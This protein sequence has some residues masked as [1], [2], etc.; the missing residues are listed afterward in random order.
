M[1]TEVVIGFL[2]VS[3]AIGLAVL[4]GFL[5]YGLGSLIDR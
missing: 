2:A 4:V 3:A 1:T 5:V